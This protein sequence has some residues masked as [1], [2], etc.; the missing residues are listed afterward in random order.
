M[1]N[2]ELKKLYTNETIKAMEWM[3]TQLKPLGIN[4]IVWGVAREF[5]G[6]IAPI[7]F[8]WEGELDPEDLSFINIVGKALDMVE[9]GWTPYDD[10]EYGGFCPCYPEVAWADVPEAERKIRLYV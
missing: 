9:V 10:E 3:E 4:P 2:P 5:K 6:V 1:L 8:L 7:A